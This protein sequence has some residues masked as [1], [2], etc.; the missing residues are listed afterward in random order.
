MGQAFLGRSA[1]RTLDRASYAAE[2]IEIAAIRRRWIQ[3]LRRALEVLEA[4]TTGVSLR[5]RGLLPHRTTKLP[6]S[7]P[8][9]GPLLTL[10]Y[11]G[12]HARK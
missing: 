6:P 3:R 12:L 8:N 10:R 9:A 7:G 1:I 4:L 5:F 11:G 2:G